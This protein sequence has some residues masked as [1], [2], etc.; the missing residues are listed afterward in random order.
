MRCEGNGEGAVGSGGGKAY[1]EMPSSWKLE[2]DG[3]EGSL[4]P[5]LHA[6]AGFAV[7]ASLEKG[8]GRWRLEVPAEAAD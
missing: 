6:R 4:V 1:S 8:G 5:A 3:A 7:A 2:L